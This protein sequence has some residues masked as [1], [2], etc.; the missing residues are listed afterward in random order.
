MEK[1]NHA[2]T[3]QKEAAV[4]SRFQCGDL[5]GQQVDIQLSFLFIILLQNR[6]LEKKNSLLERY[7]TLENEKNSICCFIEANSNAGMLEIGMQ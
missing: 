1:K 2:V 5:H 4:V 3:P 7:S 6:L